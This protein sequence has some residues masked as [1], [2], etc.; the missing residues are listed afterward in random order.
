MAML[1]RE[2]NADLLPGGRF[3]AR[4][5]FGGEQLFTIADSHEHQTL[6]TQ[7]FAEHNRTH[8]GRIAWTAEFNM[9]GS[10]AAGH[11]R[12]GRWHGK[13][14]GVSIGRPSADLWRCVA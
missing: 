1:R 4:G 2:S 14:D 8:Q 6:I 12:A 11:G 9:L 7:P 3:H 5:Q 10:Y 13:P